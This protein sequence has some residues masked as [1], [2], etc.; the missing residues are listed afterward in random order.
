MN[1]V[2]FA[3]SPTGYLHIGGMRTCLYNWLFAKKTG[4]VFVLRI[5]DTDQVRS[6][7]HYLD[8][9]LNMLKWLGLDADEGPYFQS[10]R[11]SVYHEYAAKLMDKGMAYEENEPGSS[12]QAIRF[13][14]PHK[15]VVFRDFVYGEIRIDNSLS[16]DFIIIKSDG[17][18][19]YNFA[20]VVDDALMGITHVIRGEDHVSNTPRQIAIYQALRFPLPQYVHVPMI[21]GPDGKRLSKRHGATSVGAYKDDGY[22]PQG[23]L[24]YLALLGWSPGDDREVMALEEMMGA[25][26]LERINKKSAVFDPE[27]LLWMNGQH[28]RKMHVE[29]LQ[30]MLK[31]VLEP[32]LVQTK[33]WEKLVELHQARLKLLHDFSLQT[34]YFY[35]DDI[36]YEPDA[37]KKHFA[38]E[39]SH[40]RLLEL[41]R[42]LEELDVYDAAHV[43]EVTRS[44][45]KR[46]GIKVALLIHPA[47]IA[48]TGG[49]ASPGIFGM[50]LLLGKN[51]VCE[52]LKK[53]AQW[54]TEQ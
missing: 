47:R 23:L 15:E 19:A 14:L 17:M 28:I 25:F 3:P 4:G 36:A 43:E 10:Q 38:D 22:V 8:D 44:L 16:E 40:V 33:G 24:N 50:M 49:T 46:M 2:R 41:A 39:Q 21:L 9:I 18:P 52:R 34:M 12:G 6:E 13:R 31:G 37:A 20:C 26:S 53:A 42:V 48:L 32:T 51:R 29:E 11:V 54:V 1:R 27:K 45:A 5:E 7:P 35:Q 30:E